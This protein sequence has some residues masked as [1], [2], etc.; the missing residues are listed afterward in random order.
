V[1]KLGVM[2]TQFI[3]ALFRLENLSGSYQL[4]DPVFSLTFCG[5]GKRHGEHVHEGAVSQSCGG[6][7]LLSAVSEHFA[8]EFW[9]ANSRWCLHSLH[10]R[11]AN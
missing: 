2:K 7:S 6:G 4:N 8:D 10:S 1:L 5:S 9:A 3:F 11:Y